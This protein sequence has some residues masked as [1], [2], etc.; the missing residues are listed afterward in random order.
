MAHF[1][2]CLNCAADRSSCARLAEVRNAIRGVNITSIKFKCGDR[3]PMFRR[4]QRVSFYW[5]YYDEDGSGEGCTTEFVG[6]VMREKPGNRRF[7]IRVDQ[8]GEHY[9]LKPHDI[10]KSAEFISV[11]PAD[12]RALDEPDAPMCQLCSAYNDDADRQRL[13]FAQVCDDAVYRDC[14]TGQPTPEIRREAP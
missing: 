10:L 8:D 14:W 5:R 1:S 9:D 13:C 6:T 11:R 12:M 4:G 7:S 3:Q 2:T